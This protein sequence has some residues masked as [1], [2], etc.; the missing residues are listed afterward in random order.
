MDLNRVASW[1][2][3]PVAV[4]LACPVA[5]AAGPTAAP[6]QELSV[7]YEHGRLTVHCSNAPLAGLL[8]RI[9]Q[10]TGIDVAVK[11]T[12][13]EMCRLT[14][15]EDQPVE[16]ALERLM[17]DHHLSY[18]LLLNRG[19]EIGVV[20]VFRSGQKDP[21]RPVQAPGRRAPG[22]LPRAVR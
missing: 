8:D 22:R 10:Q 20:R 12:V 5:F 13:T 9:E 14:V 4:L 19:D 16:Y 6:A 18:V 17:V 7:V 2:A 15:I 3:V 1:L 11:V 21:V